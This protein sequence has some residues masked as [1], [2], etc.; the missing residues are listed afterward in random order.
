M[1]GTISPVD[2]KGTTER[3]SPGGCIALAEEMPVHFY[4]VAKNH[5]L[6]HRLRTPNSRRHFARYDPGGRRPNV[7]FVSQRRQGSVDRDKKT[8]C[9]S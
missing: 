3:P 9:L 8:V 1:R 2:P 7:Q 4:G 6:V 5:C